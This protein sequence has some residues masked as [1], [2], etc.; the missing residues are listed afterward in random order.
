LTSRLSVV[1]HVGREIRLPQPSGQ[2]LVPVPVEQSQG[3]PD[4]EVERSDNRFPRSVMK[5]TATTGT[6]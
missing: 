2:L 5:G 3:K 6:T 1:V 4:I